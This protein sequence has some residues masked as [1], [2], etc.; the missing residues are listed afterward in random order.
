MN[1]EGD[2]SIVDETV[3]NVLDVGVFWIAKK[4]AKHGF[5]PPNF[6]D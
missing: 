6:E 1:Y 3:E 2:R 4:M 5:V